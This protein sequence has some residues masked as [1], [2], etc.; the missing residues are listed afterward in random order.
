[1]SYNYSNLSSS[2]QANSAAVSSYPIIVQD[3]TNQTGA[4]YAAANYLTG[5]TG[6]AQNNQDVFVVG[7][8]SNV[9]ISNS[10]Y[11][12]DPVS[13]YHQLYTVEVQ[14]NSQDYSASIWN[15]IVTLTNNNNGQASYF[16]LTEPTSGINPAG[17]D[18]QFLNGGVAFVSVVKDGDWTTWLTR[19]G[20]TTEW[21]TGAVSMPVTGMQPSLQLSALT[22]VTVN[23]SDSINSK[24]GFGVANSWNSVTGYGEINLDTALSLATGKALP[25]VAPPTPSLSTLN[26]GI[27]SANFQDAWT[28]GYTGKG[29][30]IA[31]IDDGIDT[32]NPALTQNLLTS[33]SQA[34]A[35][36]QGQ[37][38]DAQ[39]SHGSFVASQMTAAN[40][41]TVA[42][43]SPV[44]GGAY[45]A[46]LM[47]LNAWTYTP[48]SYHG[49]QDS[50]AAGIDYAVDNGAQIINIS[51]GQHFLDTVQ[52]A[53]QYATSKGVIV[54]ISSGNDG[55]N[56]PLGFP[57][58]QAAL[59][60]DVIAVGSSDYIPAGVA[61][62][63]TQSPFSQMANSAT[64]FNF[65]EA[66][67][68]NVLGYG[69]TSD[70][71]SSPIKI[72]GGTS[73][74]SPMVAAEAAIIEEA[75]MKQYP[76][77]PQTQ[78]AA[79]TVHDIIIGLV[80]VAPNAHPDPY[81]PSPNPY[82]PPA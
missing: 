73:F 40:L 45:G 75:L 3:L 72:N 12:A 80:G 20:G 63:V 59:F 39:G 70:G 67:G 11:K 52:A 58:S 35:L 46:S 33:V 55:G 32:L 5:Y 13:G 1:M 82:G 30:K 66:P 6:V 10:N 9:Y 54:C 64:P 7:S 56:V 16:Q 24:T 68:A 4:I 26:W 19:G 78:I 25:H 17:V 23:A 76:T 65:V 50:V 69:L 61:N 77:L 48:G 29:E 53:L 51:L 44:T 15:G 81:G 57:S 41:G 34:F 18:V 22:P 71:G 47:A 28:V 36:L 27:G 60:G 2:E 43:P 14:G 31:M 49:I 42:N 38:A 79:A 37:S 8:Q 21:N 62:I 74:S